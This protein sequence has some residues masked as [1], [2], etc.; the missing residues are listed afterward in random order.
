MRRAGA[1]LKEQLGCPLVLDLEDWIGRYA[2]RARDVERLLVAFMATKPFPAA[3]RRRPIQPRPHDC[4]RDA[5]QC[6]MDHPP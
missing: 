1:R 3:A 5:D 4:Q 6:S 2:E